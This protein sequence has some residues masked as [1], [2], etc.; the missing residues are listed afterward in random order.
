MATFLYIF[1]S[2][3]FK[4]YFC[5]IS[6]EFQ[7]LTLWNLYFIKFSSFNF[8]LERTKSVHTSYVFLWISYIYRT[9]PSFVSLNH[10]LYL[11]SIELLLLRI[12][13]IPFAWNNLQTFLLYFSMERNWNILFLSLERGSLNLFIFCIE[14]NKFIDMTYFVFSCQCKPVHFMFVVFL[15]V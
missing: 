8:V 2:P 13:F 11:L 9:V 1:E 5:I 3:R 4:E 15:C 14:L 7:S 12:Y 10:C 6:E